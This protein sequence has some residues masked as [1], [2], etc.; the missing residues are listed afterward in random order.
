DA[1]GVH[2]A[3]SP[4]ICAAVRALAGG[5]LRR[6]GRGGGKH[7]SAAALPLDPRLGL[8]LGAALR[9]FARPG[10]AGARR[11]ALGLVHGH[12]DRARDPAPRRPDQAR[13]GGRPLPAA[14]LLRGRGARRHPVLRA[15]GVARARVPGPALGAP[16]AGA[17]RGARVPHREVEEAWP[18]ARGLARAGGSARAGPTRSRPPRPWA[19]TRA[20]R[21]PT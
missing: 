11:L 15:P 16:R 14:A 20:A 9:A 6:G 13:R 18:A 8:A 3:A 4:R 7:D 10:R 5:A 17:A 2:H 19:W 1:R 21:S 12:P